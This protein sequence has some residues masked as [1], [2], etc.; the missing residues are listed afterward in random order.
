[1]SAAETEGGYESIS[2]QRRMVNI[3]LASGKK[4]VVTEFEYYEAHPGN[5]GMSVKRFHEISEEWVEFVIMGT[6]CLFF[7]EYPRN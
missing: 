4:P 6:T 2:R 5:V 1:M 3:A 7:L